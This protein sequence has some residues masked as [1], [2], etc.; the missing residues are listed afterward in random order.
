MGG[1]Q[2]RTGFWL[3]ALAALAM[4][5]GGEG[6]AVDAE[7][8]EAT[9]AGLDAEA[10]PEPRPHPIPVVTDSG[11]DE[12]GVG[13]SGTYAHYSS[14]GL[15]RLAAVTAAVGAAFVATAEGDPLA[16]AGAEQDGGW[17]V[18]V[19]VDEVWKGTERVEVGEQVQLR[20][21]ERF[22]DIRS[23]DQ[24]VVFTWMKRAPERYFSVLDPGAVLWVEGDNA[25]SEGALGT[26]PLDELRDRVEAVSDGQTPLGEVQVAPTTVAAGGTVDVNATGLTPGAEAGTAICVN[27]SPVDLLAQCILPTAT[28]L[29]GAD[30][31]LSFDDVAVDA[32]FKAMDSQEIDC[33]SG[34]EMC[35]VVVLEPGSFPRFIGSVPITVTP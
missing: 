4:S 8:S 28:A 31:T 32:T 35:A 17:E 15:E 2:R 27:S 19:T 7:A 16:V 20:A 12:N 23:G 3:A 1:S 33:T 11:P 13:V 21:S 29:A 26:V 34:P 18:A 6:R 22:P 30:G 9:V 25:V 5:C 14:L 24:V 10:A